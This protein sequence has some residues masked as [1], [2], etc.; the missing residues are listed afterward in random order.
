MGT[1]TARKRRSLLQRAEGLLQQVFHP[2]V[3]QLIVDEE[4]LPTAGDQAGFPQHPQLL[5]DVRLGDPQRCL[6]MADAGLPASEQVQNPQAR[7][8]GQKGEQSDG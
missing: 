3:G 4:P 5:G 1:G 7:R 6:Q 8:M 2:P